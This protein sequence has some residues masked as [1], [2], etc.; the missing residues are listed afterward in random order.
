M[1]GAGR[2]LIRRWWPKARAGEKRRRKKKRR[3]VEFTELPSE[4]LERGR[5]DSGVGLVS[6]APLFGCTP[7]DLIKIA[8]IPVNDARRL[9]N[10]F[11][12]PCKC[13]GEPCNGFRTVSVPCNWALVGADS[14]RVSIVCV[15]SEYFLGG[16]G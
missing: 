13:R 1:E 15:H 3:R 8:G 7:V 2:S 11:I 16:D 9:K 14:P 5:L 4:F 6:P 12:T 10:F